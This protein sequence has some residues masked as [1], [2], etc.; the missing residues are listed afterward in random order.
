M[1]LN[2]KHVLSGVPWEEE[3]GYSRAIIVN[4]F[5]Y[6]SG[7]TAT[8]ETG[9]IIGTNDPYIQTK[10]ALHNIERALL[11]AGSNLEDV[12]RTRMFV[13]D[14]SFWKEFGKAHAEVFGKIKPATTTVEVPKLVMNEMM[15]EIEADAIILSV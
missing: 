11:K 1:S 6:V 7:T 5:V 13:T 9:D 14:I 2:R 8:S 10:Q 4:N 15:I 3:V 12:V